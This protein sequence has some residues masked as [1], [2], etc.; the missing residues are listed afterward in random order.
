MRMEEKMINLGY[1]NGKFDLIENMTVPMNDRGCY[2]GDGIYEATMCRNH[3][4]F[5]LEDHIDR[6]YN[7]AEALKINIPH[8]KAKLAEILSD[9]VKKVDGEELLLY[10][11]YTRG[12]A[13]RS[14]VFGDDLTANLWI[15]IRPIAAPDTKHRVKLTVLPDTRFLH[16]D[17]K[18]LN[19][20]PAVM[21]ATEAENRGCRE[22]VLHRNGRVTECAHSNVHILKDGVL[23]T[24]PADNL[25]LPGITRAHLIRLCRSNGIP[26]A[27]E[28]YNLDELMSADE[29]LVTSST[30]FLVAADEI[31]GQ[32]VGG[33]AADIVEQ[34]QKGLLDEYMKETSAAVN[35]Q[36]R[37]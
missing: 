26:V 25:I 10:W 18:T 14:H 33:K 27:E 29:I 31:D 2:F 23:H 17:I 28:P 5:T 1:Y 15:Y 24:A 12:T 32:K 4:I 3:I 11:Q 9:M 22:A 7:S 13:P 36:Q 21:A 20:I 37:I 30:K 6:C 35:L 19:L 8:T 16:C 34:L